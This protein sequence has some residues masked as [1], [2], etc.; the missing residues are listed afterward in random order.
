MNFDKSPYVGSVVLM[1]VIE[2][3]LQKF[4]NNLMFFIWCSAALQRLLQHSNAVLL[5]AK[6]SRKKAYFNMNQVAH[7]EIVKIIAKLE[8]KAH[9][10]LPG[11]IITEY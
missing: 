9:L 10:D 6:C 3:N 4:Q 7:S 2:L 11:Y 5:L 1:S 8:K